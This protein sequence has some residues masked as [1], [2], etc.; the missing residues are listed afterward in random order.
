MLIH[1]V[2]DEPNK[3]PAIRAMLEPEHI[4]ESHL[5]G[6]AAEQALSNGVLVVDADLRKAVPVAYL[7]T[8]LQ[9]LHGVSEKLF[10]VQS[11]LRD[12]IAQAFAL[13]ATDVISRQREIMSKLARVE[14]AQERM[15]SGLVGAPSEIARC[16]AAFSSLFTAAG[17]GKQITLAD[18]KNATLEVVY[19]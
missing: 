18:A 9:D 5:L 15:K 3:I 19:G 10:V 7:K 12:M 6:T 11:H 16:A 4:V 14:L 1:Y 2:T 8:L 13:G 17:E